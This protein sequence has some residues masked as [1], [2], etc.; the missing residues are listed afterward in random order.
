MTAFYS[1][2]YK[3]DSI[4]YNA[5]QVENILIALYKKYKREKKTYIFFICDKNGHSIAAVQ[6]E[7]YSCITAFKSCFLCCDYYKISFDSLHN[8]SIIPTDYNY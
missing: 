8:I 4:A 6:P 1:G 2:Y 3:H 5:K 7:L